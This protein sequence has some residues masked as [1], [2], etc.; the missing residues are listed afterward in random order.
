MGETSEIGPPGPEEAKNWGI[1][2]GRRDEEGRR[3]KKRKETKRAERPKLICGL[4]A[5]TK[6][7]KESSLEITAKSPTRTG[8]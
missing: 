4:A 1:E 8:R 2:L 5:M 7:G 3:K 6:E